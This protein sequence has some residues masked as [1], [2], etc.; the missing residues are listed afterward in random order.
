MA[1]LTTAVDDK[2]LIAHLSEKIAPYCLMRKSQLGTAVVPNYQPMMTCEDEIVSRIEESL[3]SMVNAS[4]GK[5][6][7]TSTV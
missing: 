1:Q 4:D 2:D 3:V 7:C 6:V 5:M